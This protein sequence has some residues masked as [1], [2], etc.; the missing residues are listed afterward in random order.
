MISDGMEIAAA[1]DEPLGRRRVRVRWWAR[2]LVSLLCAPRVGPRTLQ[3]PCRR[4]DLNRCSGLRCSLYCTVHAP[5][6]TVQYMAGGRGESALYQT[7]GL[8][9]GFGRTRRTC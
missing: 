8:G 1:I 7:D 2:D 9:S 3:L 4:G 6:R 5:Y